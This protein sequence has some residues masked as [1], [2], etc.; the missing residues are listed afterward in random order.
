MFYDILD[1]KSLEEKY[2]LFFC[3]TYRE[4]VSIDIVDYYSL[5]KLVVWISVVNIFWLIMLLK[6][7]LNTEALI[8]YSDTWKDLL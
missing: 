2:V 4:K 1:Y 6:S 5:E 8:K 7:Y 3:F